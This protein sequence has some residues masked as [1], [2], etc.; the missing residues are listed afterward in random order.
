MINGSQSIRPNLGW[1]LPVSIF[2][3]LLSFAIVARAWFDYLTGGHGWRQGDWLINSN[4]GFVRRS[5]FGDALIWLSDTTGLSL[6]ATVQIIQSSLF[7]LLI[8]VVWLIALM[9]PNRRLVLLLAASPSFFLIFWTGDLQGTMRKEVFGYLTLALLALNAVL[10]WRGAAL[11]LLALGF[12]I[13]GCIGNEM[14]CFMLPVVLASFRLT[15]D[16]NQISPR[17]FDLL[18]LVATTMSVLW[19]SIALVF[20]EVG[21]L[22]GLCGPL[23]TRG[24][25]A[26]VCQ[27]ALRWLVR[28]EV[29]H[30]GEV[31]AKMDPM[32]LMVFFAVALQAL[33][34][35]AVSFNLF[36]EWR[37][38]VVLAVIA[39]VPLLPL[40]LIAT[41]WGRWTSISYSL[42]GFVL[43]QAAATGRLTQLKSPPLQFVL[44]LLV[45]ALL[46]S[47]EHTVGW[48]PGGAARS[49]LTTIKDFL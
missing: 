7:V 16:A 39:L 6:L 31:A 41:D 15:S 47:H 25:N 21:A 46:V 35:V 14:H 11:P 27:D 20:R 33:I 4:E 18:A 17:L 10:G 29:S 8:F 30:L 2:F 13:L 42:Y 36:R 24:L 12:Y 5:L 44:P 32:R 9:H 43:L 3:A 40:Y 22:D 49:L 45:L 28:G 26:S 19:L 1:L 38:L 34:P 23:T 37:Y 48:Q